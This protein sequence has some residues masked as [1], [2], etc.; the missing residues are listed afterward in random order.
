MGEYSEYR[1]RGLRGA[2]GIANSIILTRSYPSKQ[3]LSFLL[4]EGMTDKSVFKRYVNI[5]KCQITVAYGKEN[6]IDTIDI[7]E[8]ESFPGILAIADADFTVLAGTTPTTPNMLLTDAHDMETMIIQSPALEKVLDEFGSEVKI[9]ELMKTSGKE[10]RRILIEA[11]LPI[12]YLR[13]ISLLDSLSLT[14]EGLD[15]NKF[16]EKETLLIDTLKLIKNVKDKSHKPA[17]VEM[18]LHSRLQ[19]IKDDT[20]DLWHVCCGHDLVYVLSIGLCKAMGTCNTNDVRPEVLER[21]LR[22]A[23]EQAQFQNTQLYLSIQHW[24]KANRPFVILSSN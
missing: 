5:Q 17:L 15:F 8:R 3:L 16:V 13:W 22:L 23:Y 11:S 7:L 21:S 6:V 24:E 4:V 9:A 12:G 18:Q 10:I 1:Q 20:H 19:E 2:D 14:F